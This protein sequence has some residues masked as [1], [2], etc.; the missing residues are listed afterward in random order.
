LANTYTSI[1]EICYPLLPLSYPEDGSSSFF[2]NHVTYLPDY[3]ASHQKTA[4]LMAEKMP[5][6]S[7]RATFFP[8][9]IIKGLKGTQ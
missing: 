7:V 3:T 1:G 8:K 2:R 4:I 9:I 5:N 6:L